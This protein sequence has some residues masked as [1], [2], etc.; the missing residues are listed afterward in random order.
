[1]FLKSSFE[2]T[3]ASLSGENGEFRSRKGKCFFHCDIVKAFI[4]SG[5]MFC[6][7]S[8]TKKNPAPTGG[9]KGWL[10]PT[11]SDSLMH[12]SVASFSGLE[13][14]CSLLV[15]SGSRSIL[16]LYGQ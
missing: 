11:V 1:M 9:A 10:R 8:P 3:M 14:L 2:K 13:R 7:F 16:Q 5:L 15:G 6:P 12:F 4:V